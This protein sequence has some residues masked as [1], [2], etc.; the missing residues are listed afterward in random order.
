MS[1]PATKYTPRR[2]AAW[3]GVYMIAAALPLGLA[4][5]GPLPAPR[6]YLVEFGVG[7]GFIGISILAL[8]FVTSGRFARIAPVF[9][10]DVVLQY[11]RQAG[12]VA[13]A[14]VLAHP[15]V[16]ILS[17]P[18]YL[19]F[20][21]PRVNLLRA[22]ALIAV[23]PMLMLLLFTSLWRQRSG[24]A[25]EWWRAVHGVLSLGVVF[26]G[27][28]HGIQVGWYLDGLVT[29]GLWAGALVGA[30][31]LVIHS[32]VVRPWLMK[33]RPY[34]V[35]EVRR[36]LDDVHTLRIEAVDHEPM[37]FTAGQFAWITVGES[38]YSFQQHPF[39]FSSSALDTT[40]SFTAKAIGDFT[41]TWDQIS[42]GDQVFLEGP[43]GGFTLDDAAEGAVFI[44]GGIGI[45]PAMSILSTMDETGDERSAL[46]FYGNPTCEEMVFREE[47]DELSQRMNLSV[48]HVIEDPPEGWSG[49][50]GYIDK[51]L[52]EDS[53]S[54]EQRRFQFFICGPEPMMD[55]AETGLRDLGVPWTRIMTERFQIV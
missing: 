28:V 5:S 29:Q 34:Q 1:E 3:V 13:F 10:A 15:A 24:L 19:A 54:T 35:V 41:S 31:Y 44:M 48:I 53:L 43:F 26:I 16:L 45:T 23:I 2:V 50:S 17:D 52:L 20:F 51:D 46:L 18:D 11:H 49:A 39:S 12:I 33:K 38:P 40:L 9:G 14:L 7:L 30:M 4:L 25:Y 21:D 32:R 6:P 27:M 55:A 47:I 37:R 36:E 22:I 42:P 8:Q